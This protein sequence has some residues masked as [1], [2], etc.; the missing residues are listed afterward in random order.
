MGTLLIYLVIGF[1]GMGLPMLEAYCVISQT[2][3]N[4]SYAI[5]YF[6]Y[7]CMAWAFLV[8][9]MAGYMISIDC[10]G[11]RG[12]LGHQQIRWL[13]GAQCCDGRSLYSQ[14]NSQ[15][16]EPF[17]GSHML[18]FG[19]EGFWAALRSLGNLTT[20]SITLGIN[21]F[22]TLLFAGIHFTNQ[23]PYQDQ[24]NAYLLV[25]SVVAI[26]LGWTAIVAIV[27][28]Q[29]TKRYYANGGCCCV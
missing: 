10:F 20:L 6:I 2:P 11:G 4:Q 8:S 5:Y 28:R 24:V 23:V 19:Q 16:R 13:W 17:D 26:A 12:D 7:L 1:L 15:C 25:W 9:S 3:E 21:W 22:F 14:C 18:P 27:H 29:V